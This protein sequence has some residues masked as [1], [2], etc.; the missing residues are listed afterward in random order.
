LSQSLVNYFLVKY[1]DEFFS[2]GNMAF[3]ITYDSTRIFVSDL[4]LIDVCVAKDLLNSIQ[5]IPEKSVKEYFFD[6]SNLTYLDSAGLGALLALHRKASKT[7]GK[8]IIKGAKDNI[9]ELFIITKLDS[10]FE[11]QN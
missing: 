4:P 5:E 11:L 7:N 8:I 10:I 9:K 6:F 3:K 2:G 1:Y